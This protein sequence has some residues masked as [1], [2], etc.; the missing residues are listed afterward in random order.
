MP[1]PARLNR[2]RHRGRARTGIGEHA[3]TRDTWV[4][5][6]GTCLKKCFFE[7]YRFSE[8]LDFTVLDHTR[9]RFRALRPSGFFLERFYRFPEIFASTGMVLHEAKRS[10]C[11]RK[12]VTASGYGQIL[13]GLPNRAR[14]FVPECRNEH[15]SLKNIFSGFRAAIGPKLRH[16][17]LMDGKSLRDRNSHRAA[18]FPRDQSSHLCLPEH[19]PQERQRSRMRFQLRNPDHPD[20][21]IR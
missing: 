16:H 9:L 8:D 4:F 17:E 18:A 1:Q 20:F 11:C 13:D 21:C 7:T 15:G 2:R 12:Q 6:G 5:K 19:V 3:A 10:T 14:E